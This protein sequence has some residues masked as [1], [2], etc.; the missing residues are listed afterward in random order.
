MFLQS[1]KWK[2]EAQ[3]IHFTVFSLLVSSNDGGLNGG[4]G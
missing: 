3:Q 1:R 2:L 4:N